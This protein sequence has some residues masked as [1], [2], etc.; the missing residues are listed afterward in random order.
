[1]KELGT[2]TQN[3]IAMMRFGQPY[4]ALPED[5]QL[6]AQRDMQ[7]MLQS[8]RKCRVMGSA[9]LDIAY[10]ASG[11]LDLYLEQEISLWDIAAGTLMV[12]M[13]GGIIELQ[14]HPNKKDKYS[15]LASQPSLYNNFKEIINSFKK[16]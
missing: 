14:P 8:V 10:V 11:R 5:A 2:E 1:M 3:N 4:S 15:I 9:T 13:G 16:S 6:A 12:E 7:K